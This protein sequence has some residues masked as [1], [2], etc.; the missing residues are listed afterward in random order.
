MERK[1]SI[2]M[3][4]QKQNPFDLEEP[5]F[6]HPV[7]FMKLYNRSNEQPSPLIFCFLHFEM[8]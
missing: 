4:N 6:T 5:C 1:E 8:I 2:G 7:S 3:Y